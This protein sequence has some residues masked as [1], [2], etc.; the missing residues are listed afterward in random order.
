MASINLSS[1]TAS[2]ALAFARFAS[3]LLGFYGIFIN[4]VSF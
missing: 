4:F 3:F 2:V 1:I